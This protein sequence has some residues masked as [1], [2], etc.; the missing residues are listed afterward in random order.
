MEKC[1]FKPK[2]GPM[3][4]SQFH[5]SQ[6][7]VR[8]VGELDGALFLTLQLPVHGNSRTPATRPTVRQAS[9]PAKTFFQTLPWPFEPAWTFMLRPEMDCS[10]LSL[11]RQREPELDAARLA[12]ALSVPWWLC[13]GASKPSKAFAP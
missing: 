10:T 1:P 2:F 9:F 5:I 6:F 12:R 13:F 11:P 8:A 3:T 7:S 4:N